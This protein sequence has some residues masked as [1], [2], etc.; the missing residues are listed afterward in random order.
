M[1]RAAAVLVPVL[2]VLV[3][4]G[5]AQSGTAGSTQ[6]PPRTIVEVTGDADRG[7]RVERLDGSVRFTP[8]WSETRTECEE[9]HRRVARVRCK[10]RERAR[11]RGLAAV[12]DALRHARS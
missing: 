1:R 9:Y 8:T 10:A 2:V 3:L 6:A 7:F 5:L 4:L 12:R 11:Y